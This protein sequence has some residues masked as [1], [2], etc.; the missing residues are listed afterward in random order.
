[1]VCPVADEHSV[2]RVKGDGPRSEKLTGQITSLPK[3]LKCPRSRLVQN[4][5]LVRV[6]A[7]QH[8]V[9]VMINSDTLHSVQRLVLLAIFRGDVLSLVVKDLDAMV[10]RVSDDDLVLL[11]EYDASGFV[12]LAV[13][14]SF[15]TE[16][17][18]EVSISIKHLHLVSTVFT[19]EDVV[20]VV[21]RDAIGSIKRLIIV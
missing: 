3:D 8:N 14:R 19:N 11:V 1:M 6:L 18:Q 16:L 7:T 12:E 17:E 2:V 5:D 20:F 15:G 10:S 9:V 13:I 21:D 4:L